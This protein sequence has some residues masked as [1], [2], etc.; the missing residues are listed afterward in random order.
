MGS[1]EKTVKQAT[2]FRRSCP[3]QLWCW[4]SAWQLLR[5][6]ICQYCSSS[7]TQL[8]MWPCSEELISRKP[9]L[10]ELSRDL[11]TTTL[12]PVMMDKRIEMEDLMTVVMMVVLPMPP[13]PPPLPHPPPPPLPHPHHHPQPLKPMCH[14]LQLLQL[15]P[16]L[17]TSPSPTSQLSFTNPPHP[18][19][20]PPLMLPLQPTASPPQSTNPMS[21]NTPMCPPCTPG[22]T[23]SRTTTPATT[24]GPRRTET[25]T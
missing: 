7:A 16:L 2:C 3:S 6:T 8:T 22:S 21:T 13:L 24:S 15:T 18:T 17:P 20:P 12:L 19:L 5:N 25:D 11:A 4:R 23:P 9:S 10:Q 14:P 1:S